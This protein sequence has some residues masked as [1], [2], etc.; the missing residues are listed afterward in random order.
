[1][2]SSEH[3]RKLRR[4]P[5]IEERNVGLADVSIYSF[6]RGEN[7]LVLDLEVFLFYLGAFPVFL[8]RL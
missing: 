2:I 5:L 3:E 1:M 7:R 8:W 6:G 4:N